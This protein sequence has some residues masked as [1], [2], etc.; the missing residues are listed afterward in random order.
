ML[1]FPTTIVLIAFASII[2]GL[3]LTTVD[4]DKICTSWMTITGQSVSFDQSVSLCKSDLAMESFQYNNQ[5][6]I[7]FCC[8]YGS[9][10]G[11]EVGPTPKGC[12]RQ[13]ITPTLTRIVGGLEAIPHSWPWLVSIQMYGSH[14]CGGTLIVNNKIFFKKSIILYDIFRMNIPS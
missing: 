14:F 9:S 12:G 13:A 3:S 4:N 10:I 5:I 6:V 7:R 1:V 2:N 11:P 8:T